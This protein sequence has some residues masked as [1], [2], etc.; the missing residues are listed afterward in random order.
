MAD[1]LLSVASKKAESVSF[2]ERLSP[3]LKS[4][5]SSNSENFV[6]GLQEL[7]QLREKCVMKV[8]EANEY[9]LKALMR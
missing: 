9:N 6:H 4:N 2:T 8:P 1:K 7:D 5:Y 3:Y